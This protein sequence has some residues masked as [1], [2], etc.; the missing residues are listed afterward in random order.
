M[1]YIDVDKRI[2][3]SCL[4]LD[5][6]K[7]KKAKESK[8]EEIRLLYVAMTRAKEK[9]I[10]SCTNESPGQS[11]GWKRPYFENS[12]IFRDWIVLG[13]LPQKNAEKL[14][15]VMESDISELKIDEAQNIQFKYISYTDENI[16]LSQKES[17]DC[18]KTINED[19][20]ISKPTDEPISKE[21]ADELYNNLNYLY[22]NEELT[23]IPLKLSV[24]EIKRS[25]QDSLTAGW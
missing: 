14:R 16:N 25:M 10:I 3:H 4:S 17:I 11:K 24:S 18:E 15:E 21:L 20:S 6:I 22:P 12:K 1:E 23:R 5:L 7:Y 2:K 9:L 19:I 13:Y 8:A